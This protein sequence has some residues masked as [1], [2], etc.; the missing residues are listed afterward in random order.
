MR[1]AFLYS[2]TEAIVI[3]DSSTSKG[4]RASVELAYDRTVIVTTEHTTGAGAIIGDK[5][6]TS[7]LLV[8]NVEELFVRF[9][10][11]KKMPAFV[12]RR[13]HDGNLAELV[14]ASRCL[15]AESRKER[16]AST[17]SPRIG[18]I[19]A[20]GDPLLITDVGKGV[21]SVKVAGTKYVTILAEPF[22][23]LWRIKAFA[24][25]GLIGGSIW[26]TEGQ[27]M[28]VAIGEKIPSP[29]ERE[30]DPTDRSVYFIPSEEVMDFVETN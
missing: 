2:R 24:P 29:F 26:N 17:P 18:R 30:R 15:S 22:C 8:A 28:G 20:I 11:G 12:T 27:F 19:G 6:V 5:I 21:P 1:K 4:I 3:P 7:L 13:D 9:R 25:H 10:T 23:D 16:L 14:P